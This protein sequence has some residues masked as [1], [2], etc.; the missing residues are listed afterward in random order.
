MRPGGLLAVAGIVEQ[1]GADELWDRFHHVVSE[2]SARSQ[3][4]GMPRHGDR[5]VLAAI[6]FAAAPGCTWQQLPVASFESSGAAA[7]RRFTDGTAGGVWADLHR[8]VL[9]ELRCPGFGVGTAMR[10][11]AAAGPER[12]ARLPEKGALISACSGASW[13][14]RAGGVSRAPAGAGI[15]VTQTLNLRIQRAA[16]RG[17]YPSGSVADHGWHSPRSWR[18]TGRVVYLPTRFQAWYANSA[19]IPASP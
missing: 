4:G 12:I 14:A 3:G 16:Q 2:L 18:S 13:A 17:L 6:V 8:L 19:V 9:D 1:L 5:A 15:G 7:H 10:D 11:V